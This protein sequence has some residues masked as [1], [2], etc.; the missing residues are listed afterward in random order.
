MASFMMS[1]GFM[2]SFRLFDILCMVT[3]FGDV[4]VLLP[5]R[6][7]LRYT[8]CGKASLSAIEAKNISIQMIKFCQPAATEPALSFE[9]LTPVFTA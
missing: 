6:P 1:F 3:T 4:D 2:V 7:V 5:P 9:A 8:V